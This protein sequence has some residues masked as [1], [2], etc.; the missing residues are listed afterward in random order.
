MSVVNALNTALFSRLA[1]GTALVNT[2]GG[3]FIYYQQA[4]D[5]ADRPYVVWS[6]Q[7]GQQ[8][9]V[10][11]SKMFNE[12]VYIRG[13]SDNQAQA[14]T[15]D[16]Q[17]NTLMDGYA[18]SATGHTNFWTARESEFSMFDVLPDSTKVYM[19]GAMY[20]VRLSKD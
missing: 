12:L 19:A 14:G 1:G 10:T 17:I 20:R 4:P 15:I 6:Y 2:L 7:A 3:T 11:P 18:F 9:N 8:E 16:A 5:N 13:Y